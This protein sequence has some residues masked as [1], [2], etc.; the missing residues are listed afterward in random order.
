MNKLIIVADDFF[1]YEDNLFDFAE[2]IQSWIGKL[3]NRAIYEMLQV[4]KYGY[5]FII[6]ERKEMRST[7]IIK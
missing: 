1:E 7:A 2:C 4:Y 5:R 3:S 6:D